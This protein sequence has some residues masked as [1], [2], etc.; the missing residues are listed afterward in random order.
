MMT[1][2]K[3]EQLPSNVPTKPTIMLFLNRKG[4]AGK[5]TSSSN[6]AAALGVKGKKVLAIDIDSQGDLSKHLLPREKHEK[7]NSM[8]EALISG[9]ME[10]CVHESTAE[11]VDIIPAN[12]TLRIQEKDLKNNEFGIFRL[13][14]VFR[15]MDISKYD[16]VIIDPSPKQ[17]ILST[18]AMLIADLL[19]IPV[20]SYLSVDPL[21][22]LVEEVE[23][24]KTNHNPNLD[25]GYVLFTK[26]EPRTKNGK[27]VSTVRDIPIF[28]NRVLKT[29]IPKNTTLTECPAANT[30]IFYYSPT[31]TSAE[32]YMAATEE[33]IEKLG[34]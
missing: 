12:K 33:L 22:D 1:T 11:N 10:H 2:N 24:I 31:S 23:Y 5:S 29:T 9:D 6:I 30:T 20:E 13:R 17:S 32:A 21:P 27:M 3:T 18:S 26:Y 4:G 7:C 14:D 16:V 19:I 28:K 34:L 25:L 15:K 8:T